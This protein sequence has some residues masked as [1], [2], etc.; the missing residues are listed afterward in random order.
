MLAE[1]TLILRKLDRDRR[2]R[3][4]FPSSHEIEPPLPVE[5]DADPDPDHD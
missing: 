5:P 3:S 2:A 1:Q 4:E